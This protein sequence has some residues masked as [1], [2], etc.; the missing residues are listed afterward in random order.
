VVA[1]ADQCAHRGYP[2]SLGTV[3]GEVLVCGYHGF[4]YDCGGTCV[5][6]PGQDRIPSKSNVRSYRVVEQGLWVWIW[7]GR[8]EPDDDKLPETPWLIESDEWSS[9]SGVPKLKRPFT[10]WWTT[11]LTSVTKRTCIMDQ[12]G[13]PRSPRPNR[14]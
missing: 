11:C 10:C 1:L 9:V 7:M 14:G 6:V 2:L 4:T 12:S 3:V 8:G 13:R 5:A